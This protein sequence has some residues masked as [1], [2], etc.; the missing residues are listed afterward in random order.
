MLD[1]ILLVICVAG[2]LVYNVFSAIAVITGSNNKDVFW[3]FT[4]VHPV[5]DQMQLLLQVISTFLEYLII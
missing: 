1:Q 5:V 2:P 3:Y 4:L